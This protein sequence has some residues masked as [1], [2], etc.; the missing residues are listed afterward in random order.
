MTGADASRQAADAAA[1]LGRQLSAIG[2][3]NPLP[4]LAVAGVGYLVAFI[5]AVFALLSAG[6]G[7]AIVGGG[8]AT[9]DLGQEVL[10]AEEAFTG[11]GALIR[12][13]FQVVALGTFG[14]YGLDAMI[15]FAG[16]VSMS[17][18][19]LPFLVTAALV[20]TCLL[21]GSFVRRR[22]PASRLLGV[23]VNSVLGGL[24][25]ALVVLVAAR[26][27]AQ[28]I[29]TGGIGDFS[30]H[31]AGP[32]AFFGA[33]LLG[34]ASL[35]LGQLRGA[36]RP[37]WWPVV[38][39]LSAGARLMA[40]HALALMVV[41][42]IW[43]WLAH[44]VTSIADGEI[45]AVFAPLFAVPLLLGHL[46]AYATGLSAL[47]SGSAGISGSVVDL[48]G[49]GAATEWFT[50]FDLEW[51]VWLPTL[52]LSL[53]VVVGVSVLW[54]H[55]RSI[56]PGS[57]AALLISWTALPVVFFVGGII[58]LVLAHVGISV[59]ASTVGDGR[60]ALSLAPWTPVLFGIAGAVVEVSSRFLA[61]ILAPFVPA[62]MLSWFRRP[63]ASAATAPSGPV[64]VPETEP[65]AP[66]QYGIMPGDAGPAADPATPASA[67]PHQRAAVPVAAPVPAP[68][69][70]AR[71]LSAKARRRV[72][73]GG[74]AV[75]TLAVLAVAATIAIGVVSSMFFSPGKQVEAYLGAV[76]DGD[77]GQ[78]VSISP[79]NVSHGQ[80]VLLSDQ[81]GAAT[82][83]GISG[84]TI[85][86]VE[87]EGEIATVTATLEQDGVRSEQVFVLERTGRS[88]L[89]FPHWELEDV[90]LAEVYTYLPMDGSRVIEV[91]GVSVDLQDVPTEID[92]EGFEMARLP[93]LP[94]RYTV[95]YPNDSPYL[96]QM[97]IEFSISAG[98]D[99]VE[100]AYAFPSY[101]VN[102]EG[103]KAVS[104]QVVAD[105]DECAQ[106]EVTEPDGCPFSTYVYGADS[107]TWSIT[108]YPEVTLTNMGEGYFYAESEYGSGEAVFTYQYEQWDGTTTEETRTTSFSISASVVFAADGSIAIDYM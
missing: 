78:A 51:Y 77:Y 48:V 53:A 7:V 75:G 60:A 102:A 49:G 84:Y 92:E 108:T 100:P 37:A 107:G 6:I 5:A 42:G 44:A 11:I 91:N 86:S 16:E 63:A 24:V 40:V 28:P 1:Q 79:P 71:P 98:G 65:P 13:P 67:A 25:L 73:A 52:L 81:I 4:S 18:R 58:A 95:T 69:A 9:G 94:G 29:P 104:A 105:L 97:P 32:D 64:P 83:G 33:W 20:V 55:A 10:G 34:S 31:A 35:L 46:L 54:N 15:P 57:V 106:Q 47:S 99:P 19:F 38:A 89:L 80:R 103:E 90:Q 56:V 21:G 23:A 61:P 22:Q 45:G 12:L 59:Q 27:A 88:F 82:E 72:L 93:V 96:D 74:I 85:D 62:A 39:D 101:E 41:V 14:S 36:P 76:Q 66:G 43:I 30:V 70:V 50:V 2:L 8:E 87:T 17:L 68:A 3:V 26:I